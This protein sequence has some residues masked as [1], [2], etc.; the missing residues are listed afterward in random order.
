MKDESF[1]YFEG[2]GVTEGVLSA[3][4]YKPMPGRVYVEIE[5]KPEVMPGGVIMLPVSAR[6]QRGANK[7]ARVLSVGPDEDF[8]V[9]DRVLL[10]NFVSEHYPCHHRNRRRMFVRA[11]EVLAVLEDE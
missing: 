11:Q 7:S 10:S 1:G 2:A 5:L 4:R 3:S 8:N 6:L 9:G